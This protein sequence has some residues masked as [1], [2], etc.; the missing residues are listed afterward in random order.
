MR[1]LRNFGEPQR[2]LRWALL[3]NP[4]FKV[5]S[6]G[7]T[8]LGFEGH[9]FGEFAVGWCSW[10]PMSLPSFCLEHSSALHWTS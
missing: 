4:E 1:V 9:E 7:L 2:V 3:G 6:E 5:K 10:T 8:G